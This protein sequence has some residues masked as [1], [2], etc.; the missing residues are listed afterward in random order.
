MFK[1]LL[2]ICS[3]SWCSMLMASTSLPPAPF[4]EQEV[5]KLYQHIRDNI[6][7]NGA[8]IASP[9][10]SHPNYYF[11]WVRDAAITMALLE[12]DYAMDH[13]S[14]IESLLK[15][16]VTWVEKIQNATASTANQ[17]ILGEPK[18]YVTGQ[19]YAG[20][21]GRPQNDGPALRAITLL[22]FA[23]HLPQ[24]EHNQHYIHEHLYNNSLQHDSM[25]VIK[26]DLEYIAHHHQDPNFDLW[27]EV[28]GQHFFTKMVQRKALLLGSE[29]A[30]QQHDPLASHYYHQ[31]A[32]AIEHDLHAFIDITN[33][34]I[35]ATL[36]PHPGPQKVH[37][38]DMAILLGFIHGQLEGHEFITVDNP[39]LSRTFNQLQAYFQQAYRLNDGQMLPLFG[40]YP[41]D[42]YDGY[43]TNGLGNPWFILTATAAD[44]YYQ[45]AL[46]ASKWDRQQSFTLLEKGDTL[47]LRLKAYAPNL[48]FHEQINRDTAVPQ[49]AAD[50]TWSYSSIL[51]ALKARQH[52]ST[53]LSHLQ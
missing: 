41:G 6:L 29:F 4:T 48:H 21:W 26:R 42:T 9:S 11:H 1:K 30:K 38:L 2:A 19:V 24:S 20:P 35:Q 13:D 46:V 10:Q 40:R 32:M 39:L 37:E 5:T 16:Y 3:L 33:Q 14:N 50:L 31:Q 44:Y 49:G 17:D 23:T 15:N 25:G 53:M 8:V 52:L 22:Q 18:F 36:A 43:Q 51:H 27:E 45:Q 34:Q 28:Y 7:P 12:S 47:L